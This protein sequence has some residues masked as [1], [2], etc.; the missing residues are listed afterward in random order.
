MPNA[1]TQLHPF[2]LFAD[3]RRTLVGLHYRVIVQLI[4]TST[5][6]ESSIGFCYRELQEVKA[7]LDGMVN[8]ESR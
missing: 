3:I 6:L 5:Y 7:L 2:P 1:S 4:T 8:Q